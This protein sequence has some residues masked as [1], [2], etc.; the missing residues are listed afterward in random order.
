MLLGL[1]LEEQVLLLEQGQVCRGEAHARVSLSVL[2]GSQE[3]D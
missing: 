2:E 1:L 3:G